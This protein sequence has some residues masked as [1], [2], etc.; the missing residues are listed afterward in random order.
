MALPCAFLLLEIATAIQITMPALPFVGLQTGSPIN[1]TWSN[2][3]GDVEIYL[4]P[5]TEDGGFLGAPG[6]I[7]ITCK[8]PRPLVE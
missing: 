3:I 1:I 2:A 5:G 6:D 8:R 4:L 7:L